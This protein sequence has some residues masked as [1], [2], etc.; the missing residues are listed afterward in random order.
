MLKTLRTRTRKIML[1]TLILVIPSFIFFYGWGSITNSNKR[2]AN[3]KNAFGRFQPAGS[4]WTEVTPEEMSF[5]L[6]AL[7][8]QIQQKLAMAL[9]QQSGGSMN[10]RSALQTANRLIGEV[11]M[12]NLAPNTDL[13][14][15]CLNEWALNRYADDHRIRVSE[16]DVLNS[17]KQLMAKAS[18]REEQIQRL[19]EIGL[20]TDNAPEYM[21]NSERLQRA[22]LAFGGQTRATLFEMWNL[23][24]QREEKIKLDYAYLDLDTYRAQVDATPGPVAAYYAEHKDDFLVGTQRQYTYALL[25]RD[26]LDK[27]VALTENDYAKYYEENKEKYRVPRKTQVRQIFFAAD[28]S[29]A[30]T[31]EAR[32]DLTSATL[33]RVLAAKTMLDTGGDFVAIADSLSEDPANTGLDGKKLGG[34]L[35]D[36]FS[37]GEPSSEYG[38]NFTEAVSKLEAGKVAGPVAVRGSKLTGFA[39]LKAEQVK[40]SYVPALAEVREKVEKDARDVALD[41]LFDQHVEE[42]A[43]KVAG[44]VTIEQM[45]QELKL[46]TGLTSLV[47]TTAN[48]MLPVL[49]SIDEN[50][51][52]FLNDNLRKGEHSD[53]IK[54]QNAMGQKVAFVLQLKEEVQAHIPELVEIDAKVTDALKNAKGRELLKTAAQDLKT[55]ATDAA[56]LKAKAEAIK[57]KFDT[58]EAFARAS[59]PTLPG[60]E[61]IDFV[62]DSMVATTGTLGM[63]PAGDSPDSIEGYAVWRVAEVQAPSHEAF[64]KQVPELRNG[65]LATKSEAFVNE[66]LADQRRQMKQEPPKGAREE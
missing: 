17:L 7:R 53:L 39:M 1:A 60:G 36:L 15:E 34:L 12:T 46:E 50:D 2:A 33:S 14:T 66:W 31:T 19:Q 42:I 9:M 18:S 64:Q 21:A 41:T 43:S 28:F 30:T 20:T 37:E 38:P 8:P 51:L 22:R 11:G 58:T 10:S 55:G 25:G 40:D 32:K 5:A 27:D 63:S 26:S 3:A 16:D 48:E 29:K 65:L 47:L 24:R 45:A 6:W 52:T 44:Y 49:G 59:I 13:Y 35:P 54:S 23:Y 56:A 57:A 61:W 4:G 62:R